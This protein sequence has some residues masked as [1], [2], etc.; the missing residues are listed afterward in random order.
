MELINLQDALHRIRMEY[1]EMPEMRLTTAQMR[2]LLNLPIDV[3]EGALA[4]L[5]DSGFLVRRR[6]G[7]FVR[8][9][10]LVSAVFAPIEAH[11]RVM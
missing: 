5:V 3:C 4:S 7:S 9:S 1:T 10:A 8:G 11:A 2:R 6:D